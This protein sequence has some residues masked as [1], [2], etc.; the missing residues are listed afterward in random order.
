MQNSTPAIQSTLG[1]E[2]K[3]KSARTNELRKVLGVAFGIALIV[4]NVI[5]AGIL[6]NPGTVAHYVQN[7]WLIVACWVFGGIYVLTAVGAYA[8]MATMLPKAGGGY[9]YVK[10]A[11]GNYAGFISGWFQYL[12]RVISPAYY[13][14]LIGEYLV[15]LIPSLGGYEK[16]I[17]I[18]FLAAFTFYHLTGVKNG[19]LMQQV[20]CIIKVLCFATLI[21][22]CF[23]YNGVKINIGQSASLNTVVNGT[24]LLGILKSLEL[25]QGTYGGWDGLAVFAEEDEDP[26]RN[27]P[28]S[29][30]RGAIIVMIIYVLI[31]MAFLHVLPM[32]TLANSNLAAAD[33]AKAVFGNQGAIIVTVIALLS[34]I[35][36]FN[37]HL[38]EVLRVLFGLSRDGFFF[39]KGTYV[40]KKGTPVTALIFSAVLSLIL[41]IIGSFN[42][43]FALGGFIALIVPALVYASLIKLRIKEPGLPRPYRAW[44]Y[45]YT[46]IAMILISV[47]LFIGFA[48]SD[49]SNFFVI[50]GIIILS[51]P[52]FLLIRK[53]TMTGA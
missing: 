26:G 11:F 15:L 10:R 32:S 13:S 40:N 46:T 39:A 43:L 44:G 25:I 5:G 18:S 22:S 17:A 8:E 19:S 50:A 37:G 51:Y 12:K 2:E 36:A 29:F 20:T 34:I 35:G 38:M 49:R 21:I 31:N 14:I 52:I 1:F 41:I 45:P 4:G 53:R 28:R 6:R 24:I 3:T 30:Y 27:I 23:V 33:A 42:I 7:Y 48:I 9:N 47:A 16:S